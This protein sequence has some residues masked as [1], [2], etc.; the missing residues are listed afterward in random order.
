MTAQEITAPQGRVQLGGEER[1]V[2]F[3]HAQIRET[4]LAWQALTGNVMGYLGIL[5]QADAGVFAALEALMYGA[6]VSAQLAGGAKRKECLR[7][8]RFDRTITY[9]EAQ[10]AKDELVR[11][12]QMAIGEP[13]GDEKNA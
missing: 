7:L 3:D 6:M 5:Y 4:E 8:V 1:E 10:A 9:R 2:R 13:G 11:L 12:A